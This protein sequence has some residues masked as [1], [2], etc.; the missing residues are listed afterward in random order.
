MSDL[1]AELETIDLGD[2]RLNERSRRVLADLG[3][4]PGLSIPAACGGWAETKGAY[5]LFDHEQVT[6]QQ[7]LEPHYRCSEQRLRHHPLVLCLQATSELD[8][9]D[10]C[11]LSRYL[12]RNRL[13]YSTGE[14][15][16]YR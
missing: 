16:W 15:F 8:Y 6:A 4:Q 5:R 11:Y 14:K 1:V 2:Q 7:V 10:K 12:V 3:A 13:R 9:T